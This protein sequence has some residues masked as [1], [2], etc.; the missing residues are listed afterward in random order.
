M[1]ISKGTELQVLIWHSGMREAFLIHVGSTP[2][3]IK[4]KGY[5]KAYMESNK[6]YTE[7]CSVIKQAKA[8]LAE[9]D[10]SNGR[11]AETSRKS[12]KKSNMTTLRP[13]QLTQPCK[14]ISCLRSNRPKKPQTRP[15]P[16]ES[17]LLQ[18][19]SSSTQIF[20]QS[21]QSMHGT[22][23]SMSRQHLTSTQ[24]FKSV[25]RMDPGDFCAS[26]SITV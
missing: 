13:V 8:Q 7:Q 24:T 4:R 21:V 14:L 22:R 12:N 9:L 18:T 20:C 15:R 1:Q 3:S 16:R 5:F 25:L 19:C 17:K 10:D 26:H 11:E 2:E 6:V 23:L